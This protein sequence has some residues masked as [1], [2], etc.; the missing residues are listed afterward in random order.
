MII[1]K[2]F[3]NSDKREILEA[4]LSDAEMYGEKFIEVR[5]VIQGELE[6]II[7]GVEQ[8]K[9]VTSRQ[10]GQKIATATGVV[11][12]SDGE[13]RFHPDNRFFRWGYLLDTP[14]NRRWL[15]GQ[16]KYPQ[17]IIS[18]PAIQ[19]EIED[20]A[21]KEGMATEAAP[22]Q[23]LAF[24]NYLKGKETEEEIALKEKVEALEKELAEAKKA[25]AKPLAGK[26]IEKNN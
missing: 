13:L 18:D 4:N 23:D 5:S 21:R 20:L 6:D 8:A 19:K 24:D 17:V 1:N 3:M 2:K 25:K 22:V 26:K 9:V 16:L 15:A 12:I 7:L 10:F 11:R 14:R